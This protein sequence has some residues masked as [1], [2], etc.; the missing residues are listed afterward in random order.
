MMRYDEAGNGVSSDFLIETPFG[1]GMLT[2]C[3]PG[4]VE[5]CSIL[6]WLFLGVVWMTAILFCLGTWLKRRKSSR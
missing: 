3:C 1:G 4:S 2:D 6:L 5:S